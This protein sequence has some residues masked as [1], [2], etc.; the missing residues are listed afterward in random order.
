[1]VIIEYSSNLYA[2]SNRVRVF[3]GVFLFEHKTYLSKQFAQQGLAP[4]TNPSSYIELVLIAHSDC[5]HIFAHFSFSFDE[6]DIISIEGM[7]G[8]LQLFMKSRE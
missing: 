2:S 6:C 7:Q 8:K 3:N 1:V 5:L 4:L